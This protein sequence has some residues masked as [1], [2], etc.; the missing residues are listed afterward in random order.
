MMMQEGYRMD[1]EWMTYTYSCALRLSSMSESNMM[2]MNS[3]DKQ[4]VIY[5][6]FIKDLRRYHAQAYGLNHDGSRC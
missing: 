2:K 5:M 3:C 1:L 6:E 4:D